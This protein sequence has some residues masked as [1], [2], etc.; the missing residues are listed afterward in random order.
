[1]TIG[2]GAAHFKMLVR[3]LTEFVS[4]GSSSLQR[5]FSD[6]VKR[7]SIRASI[8]TYSHGRSAY[9]RRGIAG[10][11]QDG[12]CVNTLMSVVLTAPPS[13]RSYASWSFNFRNQ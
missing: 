1:M 12:F 3:K 7:R 9:S 10:L 2:V 4:V 5:V 13:G 8:V 6:I 11:S